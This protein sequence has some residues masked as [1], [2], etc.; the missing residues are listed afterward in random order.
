MGCRSCGGGR[1][2]AL[3]RETRGP[4]C[5]ACGFIYDGPTG[6]TK[7]IRH[8]D[9]TGHVVVGLADPVP[10][11]E[12]EPTVAGARDAQLEYG[13]RDPFTGKRKVGAR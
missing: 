10:E 9:E 7:A 6:V 3:K 11:P 4:R 2:R 5:L 12:P 13:P 1:P 8:R